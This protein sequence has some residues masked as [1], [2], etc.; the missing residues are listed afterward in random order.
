MKTILRGFR[1]S[2]P[3]FGEAA[4]FALVSLGAVGAFTRVLSPHM[5]AA[6][7]AYAC[8]LTGLRN[9]KNPSVHGKWMASG[10]AIDVAIVLVLELGRDAVATALA[11]KLGPLQ[12]IHIAASSVALVLY[13][14]LVVLGLRRLRG[15][16]TPMSGE[17]H[18]RL[19]YA[20]FAFRTVGF[21]FMFSL[22]GANGGH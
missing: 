5:M 13:L 15:K 12:Q 20:A 16:G 18:R 8:F 22:V 9:R 1:V 4:I 14:P 17:W 11:F 19:G 21:L 10:V 3:E 6:T 7:L 2:R